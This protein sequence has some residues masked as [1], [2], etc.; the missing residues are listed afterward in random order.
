MKRAIA[1]SLMAL[2]LIAMNFIGGAPATAQVPVVCAPVTTNPTQWPAAGQA[3]ICGTATPSLAL[4]MRQTLETIGALP[5]DAAARLK[6]A[7]FTASDTLAITVKDV[8]A[9]DITLGTANYTIVG[10]DSA[11]TVANN[12]AADLS[13]IHP[14]VFAY[15]SGNVIEVLSGN[16]HVLRLVTQNGQNGETITAGLPGT[17]TTATV[18]GDPRGNIT[19]YFFKTHQEYYDSTPANGGPPVVAALEPDARGI[20]RV[21][22][23]GIRFTLVFET[24][25]ADGANQIIAHTTAHETGHQLDYIYGAAFTGTTV[26]SEAITSGVNTPFEDAFELDKG[27]MAQIPPCSF[28]A[29]DPS[30][31]YVLTGTNIPPA[32]GGESGIYTAVKDAAGA[33]ICSTYSD[34]GGTYEGEGRALNSPHSGNPLAIAYGGNPKYFPLIHGDPNQGTPAGANAPEMFAEQVAFYFG[35][36][37]LLDN[38]GNDITG[39]DS[40]FKG[41]FG[42]GVPFNC[43][44]LHVETLVGPPGRMPNTTEQAG[45]GYAIPVGSSPYEIFKWHTCDGGVSEDNYYG[46]YGS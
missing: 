13:T 19:Y 45:R 35:F 30:G 43:S 40:I 4:L 37:D 15:A 8:T 25:P 22:T 38:S 41:W 3:K 24:T 1:F 39:T 14:D 26:Y 11:V 46:Y 33:Q 44:A 5:Y 32:D 12:M 31:A 9:G 6:Y 18:E 23:G 28:L 34:G 7:P 36:S 10:T 21:A 2:V 29:K 27:K 42:M 20:T 17:S 16:G